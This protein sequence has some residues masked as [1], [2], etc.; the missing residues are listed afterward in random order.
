LTQKTGALFYYRTKGSGRLFVQLI[1]GSYVKEEAKNYCCLKNYL[2]KNISEIKV[3]EPEGTYLVWLDFNKL[4]EF[5]EDVE[6]IFLDKAKV[7]SSNGS[8]FGSGGKG[9][10]RIHIACSKKYL[11]NLLSE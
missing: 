6:D 7:K 2:S 11:K 10:F 5:Y 9:L 4:Y 3:V 8:E 1:L